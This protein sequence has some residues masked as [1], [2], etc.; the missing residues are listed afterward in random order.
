MACRYWINYGKVYVS[1]KVFNTNICLFSV[2]QNLFSLV[3]CL[4]F[5]LFLLLLCNGDVESN[6]GRKKNKE[7]SLPCC[8]WNVNSLLAHNGAKETSLEACNSVFKYDLTL[9]V[10]GKRTMT[11]PLL[12]TAIILIFQGIN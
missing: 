4:Y 8:H 2:C 11:Q 6:P 9:F 1:I 10:S 3:Y 5:F 7:S 12:L